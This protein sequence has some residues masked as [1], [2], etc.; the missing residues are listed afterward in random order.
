MRQSGLRREVWFVFCPGAARDRPQVSVEGDAQTEM[1]AF[2]IE[3]VRDQA[4]LEMK[5][6][7]HLFLGGGCGPGLSTAEY[8]AATG[9][10]AS[11]SELEYSTRADLFILGIKLTPEMA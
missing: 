9:S 6:F 2:C 3:L 8:C 7:T 11:S 10:G 4:W 5:Y 1:E